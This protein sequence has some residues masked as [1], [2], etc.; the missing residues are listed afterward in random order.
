MTTAPQWFTSAIWRIWE[1]AAL[2]RASLVLAGRPSET[3]GIVL[4]TPSRD[5]SMWVAGP[6]ALLVAKIHKIAERADARDRV[7]DKGA[8]DV[9]RLLRAIATEELARRV[10]RLLDDD[11]ARPVTQEAENLLPFLFADQ[12]SVAVQMAVRA[13]GT[14]EVR[15]A[16]GGG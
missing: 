16:A 5:V 4:G 14:G 7:R 6:G 15:R 9:V 12:D 8:L 11:L 13:A 3:S 1:I 10:R 2:M